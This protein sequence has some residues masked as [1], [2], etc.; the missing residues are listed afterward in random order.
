MINWFHLGDENMPV[1]DETPKTKL[2]LNKRI[3]ADSIA[4]IIVSIALI[5]LLKF[6]N[7]EFPY[8]VAIYVVVIL[9]AAL[10]LMIPYQKGKENHEQINNLRNW[11]SNLP[12][13]MISMLFLFLP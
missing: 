9:A 7:L 11:I 8:Q 5:L 2:W 1:A 6:P 13:P 3:L 12:E 4:L 10:P